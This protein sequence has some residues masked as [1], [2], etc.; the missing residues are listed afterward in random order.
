MWSSAKSPRVPRLS[1]VLR[2]DFGLSRLRWNQC[3]ACLG[4]TV[5]L[6]LESLSSLRRNSHKDS[7][8]LVNRVV[9]CAFYETSLDRDA[10]RDRRRISAYSIVLRRAVDD[11]VAPVELSAWID[12]NGG[13]EQVR[14][15]RGT[16]LSATAKAQVARTSVEASESYL[17]VIENTLLMQKFDAIDFDRTFVAVIVPRG[18]GKIEIRAVLK[19]A[20]AINAS[21]ASLYS[22]VAQSSS[23]D[24]V[25]NVKTATNAATPELIA[26]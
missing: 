6:R 4:I 23:A 2:Y 5:Q 24:V 13:I 19:N 12:A 22:Q 10:Q 20:S 3:P 17:A 21:L 8:K 15:N 9:K 11:Q 25:S 14:L 18:D 1:R 7:T 16:A 26:A